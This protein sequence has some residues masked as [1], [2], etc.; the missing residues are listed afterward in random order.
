MVH[1]YMV[2]YIF[3]IDIHPVGSFASVP[4]S[5]ALSF[6]FLSLC[7]FVFYSISVFA[8]LFLC[9]SIWLFLCL[10]LCLYLC[11]SICLYLF[12]APCPSHCLSLCLFLG[13]I[14]FSKKLGQRK[15]LLFILNIF[16]C[17]NIIL[18]ER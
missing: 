10:S 6:L 12:L 17:L 1:S 18:K 8:Y 3:L 11:L 7:I 15:S 13:L 2:R 5:G 16:I 4:F 14:S 9:L